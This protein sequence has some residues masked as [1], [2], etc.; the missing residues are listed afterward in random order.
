MN[1]VQADYQS[2]FPGFSPINFRIW[3]F[4]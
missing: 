2:V 3:R 4:K 1:R